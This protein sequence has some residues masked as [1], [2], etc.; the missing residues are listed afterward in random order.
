MQ[1]FHSYFSKERALGC[2]VHIFRALWHELL[3]FSCLALLRCHW[4]WCCLLLI[5]IEA[6]IVINALLSPNHQPCDWDVPQTLPWVTLEVFSWMWV[7]VCRLGEQ[8]N[9][10]GIICSSWWGR[11]K[12]GAL[13]LHSLD[14]SNST[15]AVVRGVHRGPLLFWKALF[16]VLKRRRKEATADV[17]AAVKGMLR[18]TRVNFKRKPLTEMSSATGGGGS[19]MTCRQRRGKGHARLQRMA[20]ILQ[21]SPPPQHVLHSEMIQDGGRTTVQQRGQNHHSRPSVSRS[22]RM[23]RAMAT[24][25]PSDYKDRERKV[26]WRSGSDPA[27]VMDASA[28]LRF[29]W[30]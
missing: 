28:V 15:S 20:E 27:V 13:Y 10:H 12:K 25:V 9:V 17:W 8:I 23:S 26:T 4:I 16:V 19:W 22:I 7:I 2:T 6:V 30:A 11:K 18:F 1:L 3:V 24:N 21:Q 29:I 14:T 5:M